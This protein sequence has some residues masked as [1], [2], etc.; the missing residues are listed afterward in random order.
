MS[1]TSLAQPELCPCGYYWECGMHCGE[2]HIDGR[3]PPY[4]ETE[5]CELLHLTYDDETACEAL[6]L[7][8]IPACETCIPQRIESHPSLF[9][10]RCANCKDWLAW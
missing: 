6:R 3:C 2:G 10:I 8:S 9:V 5:M 1:D 7:A 4:P